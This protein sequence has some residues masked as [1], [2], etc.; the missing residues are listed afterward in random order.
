MK[1][2]FSADLHFEEVGLHQVGPRGLRG[3]ARRGQAA[4]GRSQRSGTI[5]YSSALLA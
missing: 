4:A 5:L 1:S 2:F 3:D